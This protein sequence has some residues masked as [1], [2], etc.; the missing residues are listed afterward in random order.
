MIMLESGHWKPSRYIASTRVKF[1]IRW[2]QRA[3]LASIRY[4]MRLMD[5][6]PPAS[7]TADSPSAIDCAAETIAC[8]PDAQA[9]LIV[10]A[11]AACG[12]PARCAT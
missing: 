9:L 1:P 4:G 6:M 3:S 10:N 8:R 12:T 7:T 5:S 11:G 2:P